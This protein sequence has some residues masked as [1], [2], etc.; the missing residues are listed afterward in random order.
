MVITD[1]PWGIG[2]EDRLSNMRKESLT[3]T[4]DTDY[5]IMDTLDVLILLHEQNER[6]HSNL[7]VLLQLS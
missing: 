1:P 2:F 7:Y 4:Y 5:D 6:Q 3:T